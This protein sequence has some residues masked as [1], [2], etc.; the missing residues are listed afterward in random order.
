VRIFT[1]IF[2]FSICGAPIFACEQ[3]S[4][5]L[6]IGGARGKVVLSSWDCSVKAWKHAVYEGED[7]TISLYGISEPGDYIGK[8]VFVSPA[9][10]GVSQDGGTLR[11]ERVVSGLL[12]LDDGSRRVAQNNYC[13]VIDLT[14]GCVSKSFPAESCAGRWVGNEWRLFS[15]ADQRLD[16]EGLKTIPPKSILQSVSTIKAGKGK[17]FAISDYLYM[18][19]P[20]YFACYPPGVK[21]AAAL[22][23]LGF[24]LYDGGDAYSALAIFKEVERIDPSRMVLKLNIADALWD[25]SQRSDARRYYK[26]YERAMR[27]AGRKDKI[28]ARVYLRKNR[29]VNVSE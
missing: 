4:G 28:P 24:Y 2:L 11:V 15:S 14:N 29:F 3:G 17:A 7:S 18:G 16:S 25:R 9:G 13:D 1:L 27:D 26:E 10:D 8:G 22:N 23:D 19:L 6:S 21:D 5:S 12:Y 20:S